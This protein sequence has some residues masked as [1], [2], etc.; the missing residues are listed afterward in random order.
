MQRV[1]FFCLIEKK[2]EKSFAQQMIS[3][4][5][6]NKRRDG[7]IRAVHEH[8]FSSST[9]LENYARGSRNDMVLH[10]YF[11]FAN[12]NKNGKGL[13]LIINKESFATV[14]KCNL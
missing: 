5:V 11:F 8:L 7:L 12:K 10:F 13:Q 1:L 9:A 3:Y 6:G 4:A 2:K 14:C